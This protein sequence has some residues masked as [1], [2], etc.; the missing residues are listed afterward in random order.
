MAEV[1]EY[2]TFDIDR[3]FEKTQE[4]TVFVSYKGEITSDIITSLMEKTESVFSE[5]EELAKIRKVSFHIVVECLQNLFHHGLA[6]EEGKGKFGVYLLIFSE[7]VLRIITG[8]Y[9]PVSK[10]QLI[11]DRINQIN[12][13]SKD[14]LKILYKLILNNEEF[15]EKGGGGLGMIDIARKTGA[16]LMSEFLTVDEKVLFYVLKINII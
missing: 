15:S 16:K 11:S 12:S 10:V 5:N 9:I 8:N 3:W 2:M 7:G 14:E 1:A 6:I 13:M 4:G